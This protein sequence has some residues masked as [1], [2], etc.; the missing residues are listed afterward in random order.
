M[1]G[2]EV[3][4]VGFQSVWVRM[5][6]DVQHAPIHLPS[7][8]LA[9][10]PTH[11]PHP[12]TR[13]HPSPTCVQGSQYSLR[14]VEVVTARVIPD[15]PCPPAPPLSSPLGKQQGSQFSLG[16]VEVVTATVDLD[17]V[18]SYRGAVASLQEQASAAEPVPLVHVDFRWA[19][20]WVGGRGRW[21]EGGQGGCVADAWPSGAWVGGW[22]VGLRGV[23]Q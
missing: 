2:W 13:P 21:G 7:L 3:L 1:C 16:E 10:S 19:G 18:V 20:G 14:E 4:V 9:A 23:N 6:V 11:L 12:D 5:A 15:P 8:P 17:E 22:V